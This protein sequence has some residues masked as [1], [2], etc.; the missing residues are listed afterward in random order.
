MW[1]FLSCC[2]FQPANA[3]L[4]MHLHGLKQPK[5]HSKMMKKVPCVMHMKRPCRKKNSKW[6]TSF[7]VSTSFGSNSQSQTNKKFSSFF[8]VSLLCATC[9]H[10]ENVTFFII[11]EC[12]LLFL[13]MRTHAQ[14]C[15]LWSKYTILSWPVRYVT[16]FCSNSYYLNRRYFIPLVWHMK[17]VL[18]WSVKL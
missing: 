4:G 8:F 18:C 13:T 7:W 6:V 9:V 12:F 1:P 16:G 3:C 5:K 15:I 2:L 11:F 14:A 17:L 10:D